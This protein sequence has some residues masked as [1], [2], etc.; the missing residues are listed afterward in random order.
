M[1]VTLT[2]LNET[3]NIATNKGGNFDVNN[4]KM[5]VLQMIHNV[6]HLLSEGTILSTHNDSTSTN[7]NDVRISPPL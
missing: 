2:T 3:S 4:N 1:N 6:N 5:I 7:N